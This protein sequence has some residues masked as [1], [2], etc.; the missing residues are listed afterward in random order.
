MDTILELVK[1]QLFICLQ[2]SVVSYWRFFGRIAL[3][4]RAAFDLVG[5]EM[6]ESLNC[7]AS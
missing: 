3:P 1:G 7:T 5:V 4:S 6:S 2:K